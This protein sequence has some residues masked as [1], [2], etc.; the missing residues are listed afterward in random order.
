MQDPPTRTRIS[1]FGFATH[2]LRLRFTRQGRAKKRA[3]SYDFWEL[4]ASCEE[5]VGAQRSSEGALFGRAP[6]VK[7]FDVGEAGKLR[8]PKGVKT[9]NSVSL[10]QKSCP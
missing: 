10:L 7:R 4:G 3:V 5:E 1:Y 9:Q 6:G 8:H 2:P